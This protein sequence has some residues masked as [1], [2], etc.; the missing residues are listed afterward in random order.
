MLHVKNFRHC[1]NLDKEEKEDGRAF[2]KVQL[3]F[4]R[5]EK[6][7]SISHICL[8]LK[9]LGDLHFEGSI[10]SNMGVVIRFS[11]SVRT[12]VFHM[13]KNICRDFM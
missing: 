10:S 12:H 7:G 5:C 11:T 2:E 8:N 4:I 3:C 1:G 9:G 6:K 13:I